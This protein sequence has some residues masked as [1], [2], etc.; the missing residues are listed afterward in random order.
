MHADISGY[1]VALCVAIPACVCGHI[2]G[3]RVCTAWESVFYWVHVSSEIKHW[4]RCGRRGTMTHRDGGRKRSLSSFSQALCH[5]DASPCL[6]NL[7][8]DTFQI[9]SLHRLLWKA[10]YE[11]TPNKAKPVC[12]TMWPITAVIRK[13]AWRS[14]WLNSFSPKCGTIRQSW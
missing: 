1:H 9:I 8:P 7:L 13:W 5:P 6:S 2:I 3:V 11:K 4:D 12:S 10:W 14:G